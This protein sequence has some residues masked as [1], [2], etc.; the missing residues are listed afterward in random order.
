MIDASPTPPRD[1]FPSL[2][3]AAAL[4]SA[5]AAAALVVLAFLPRPSPPI[6]HFE[7]LSGKRV[8]QPAE[9]AEYL[10]YLRSNLAG[11][12][13][14]LLGHIGTWW[15]YAARLRRSAPGI[16]ALLAGLGLLSGGLDFVENEI[17]WALLSTLREGLPIPAGWGT[18]WELVVGLS[19]WAIFIPALLTAATL[20][21]RH[22]A[23]RTMAC[24][25]SVC[26]VTAPWTY[27]GG[28]FPSFIWLITWHAASAIYLWKRGTVPAG[29][30]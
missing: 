4:A 11:D 1:P 20:W 6:S 10:A 19:F 24:L 8:L 23:D 16:A 26:A 14:Y 12:S 3:R 13:L 7:V 29:D 9:L 28:F 17:R 2:T 30:G 25:A 15:G 27:Y 5:V 21:S 18:V 22:P